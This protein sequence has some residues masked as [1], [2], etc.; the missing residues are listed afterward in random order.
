MILIKLTYMGDIIKELS[1]FSMGELKIEI[2]RRTILEREDLINKTF[3]IVCKYYETTQRAVTTKSS[4]K[5]RGHG[6]TNERQ[7]KRALCYIF[8]HEQG[9]TTHK[10]G[11]IMNRAHSTC[12]VS[13]NKALAEMGVSPKYKKEIESLI[14]LIKQ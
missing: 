4:A 8:H 2:K 11:A 5:S 13:A 6:M 3:D 1:K 10:T 12:T 14:K 7:C 9:Y